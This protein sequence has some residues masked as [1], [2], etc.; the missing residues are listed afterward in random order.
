M[1]LIAAG[2]QLYL[3]NREQNID[4][5]DIARFL[6]LN[7]F[8]GSFKWGDLIDRILDNY[9]T[10]TI[11]LPLTFFYTATHVQKHEF[12]KFMERPNAIPWEFNKTFNT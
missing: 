12:H 4:L 2:K 8:V 7:P 3:Q 5:E 9:K 1:N 6:T 10:M 11:S